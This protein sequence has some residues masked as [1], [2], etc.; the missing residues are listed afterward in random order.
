MMPSSMG[1]WKD[2]PDSTRPVPPHELAAVRPVHIHAPAAQSFARLMC[3]AV[4]RIVLVLVVGLSKRPFEDEIEDD[5]E[6]ERKPS[7]REAS[8][9]SWE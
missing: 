7:D 8:C 2:C 4:T 6:D 5:D 9:A 3:S 1:P